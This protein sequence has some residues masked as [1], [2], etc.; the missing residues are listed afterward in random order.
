MKEILSKLLESDLL[1]PESREQITEAFD[2]SMQQLIES[3]TAEIQATLVEQFQADREVLIN[4][5]EEF[6]NTNLASELNELKEDIA[7]ANSA[8]D[9]LAVAHAAA[10]VESR[11]ELATVMNTQLDALVE[12]L[13]SFLEERMCEEFIEL[14]E[15][16]EEARKAS[17]GKNL[18]EAYAKEF[19][20]FKQA[21]GQSVE[22]KNAQLENQVNELR[23]SLAQAE[24]SAAAV[25]RE[26][27]MNEVLS[28]LSGAKR[29]QMAILLQSTPVEK[30]T[31]AYARF[32]PRVLKS[33][34]ASDEVAVVTES[35]ETEKPQGRIFTGNKEAS[36]SATKPVIN[37]SV[38]AEMA[39]LRR[40][41]GIPAQ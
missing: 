4:R 3:K 40:M 36:V 29:E 30:L 41:A 16:I 10:L 25:L 13:D 26:N 18:F 9:D 37:E 34:A 22:S 12:H 31:E 11:K 1:T 32:I 27:K 20:Q 38:E 23:E 6:L 5:V 17:F 2:L 35:V 19:A 24:L 14:K 28:A 8:A 33:L 7:V 15:D 39:E 21:D